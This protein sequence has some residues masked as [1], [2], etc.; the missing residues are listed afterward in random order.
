MSVKKIAILFS[1]N[2]SNLENILEKVHNKT[3]NGVTIKC[4]LLICNNPDA[5]G[6]QR[7]EK[8]GLKTVVINHKEFKTRED[9][10]EKLANLIQEKKIDL[11]ILAGFM[12]ILTPVFT[13]NIKAINLHPS[14]LPLF[15]GGN[16]IKES[17]N[18]DMLVGGVSVHFVSEELDGGKLI[19]QLVFYRKKDMSLEE[20][21]ENIHKLE[22]EILPKTIIE[23]L[24]FSN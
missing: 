16:A 6:I 13:K 4:D 12:R 20:W 3:F 1:G 2:G 7:A 9:F 8:F 22:Y 5:F 11:A 21:E 14:I 15:K 18:S 17:F 23:L 10:D 24:A 19:N